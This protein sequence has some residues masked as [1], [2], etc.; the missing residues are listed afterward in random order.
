M[1]A[2][3]FHNIHA[4]RR[5]VDGIHRCHKLVRL[6]A[7]KA[8]IPGC[9]DKALASLLDSSIIIA[10]LSNAEDRVGFVGND[11]LLAFLRLSLVV[12][13]FFA[14][15]FV[16]AFLLLPWPRRRSRSGLGLFGAL[17]RHCKKKRFRF[18]EMEDVCFDF[19][20]A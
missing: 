11:L 8:E 1:V 20:R 17:G 4:N 14:V 18:G 13:Y 5:T 16:I 10:L 6:E 2:M 7:L 3:V 12:V 9:G 19:Q 15:A